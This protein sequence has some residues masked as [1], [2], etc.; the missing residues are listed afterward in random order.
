MWRMDQT[1]NHFLYSF[2]FRIFL[3]RHTLF[4]AFI[5]WLADQGLLAHTQFL[6][7]GEHWTSQGTPHPKALLHG[8]WMT[9]TRQARQPTLTC[10]MTTMT[11]NQIYRLS[12]G[13]KL[14][15]TYILLQLLNDW[16]TEVEEMEK[17]R[18]RETQQYKS[19]IKGI[20]QRESIVYCPNLF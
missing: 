3:Q 17:S 7:A 9:A 1:E 16:N 8:C 11:Y 6:H 5:K 12:C 18:I 2:L 15:A 4:H 14:R 13:H 20:L 19:Q 10:L